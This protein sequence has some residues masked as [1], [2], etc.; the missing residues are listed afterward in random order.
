MAQPLR[1]AASAA[2]SHD[3]PGSAARDC[4]LSRAK[5]GGGKANSAEIDNEN[6]YNEEDEEETMMAP[7]QNVDK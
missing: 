2:R 3:G 6:Y 1:A 7:Q 5:N 4:T